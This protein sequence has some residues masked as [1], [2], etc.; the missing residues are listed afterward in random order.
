[1]DCSTP[2]SSFLHY[3]PEFAQI[4]VHWIDDATQPICPLLP[5]SPFAFNLSQH[6]SLLQWVGSSCVSGDQ[7]IGASASASVLPM[8]IQCWFP[9]GLMGLISLQSKGLSRV[10]S[11]F[12]IQKHQFCS[13]Q[14]SLCVQLSDSY[15]TTGK[16]VA[17][18]IQ[19]FVSKMMSLLFNMLSRFVIAFLPRSKYLLISWLP[20]PSTVILEP[21]KIKSVT[22]SAFS[23]SIW[24]KVMGLDAMILV[25]WMLSFKPAFSLYS[26][27]FI[28][29]LFISSS[30][31]AIL[32]SA[33]VSSSPVFLM[34]YSAYKLNKQGDNIQPS[35]FGT[36]LL[37]HVQF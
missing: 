7:R 30:L 23:P 15:I 14:P 37:F 8:N 20:S 24:H 21:K 32:I 11:S 16:T 35:W 10:F 36:C 17:L 27:T 25:F 28:K 18:T 22:A 13:A 26:F 34:I 1:M 6:Q 4:D 2:G 3:P 29:R 5:P 31:S 12:T 33:C 9:L 19:T